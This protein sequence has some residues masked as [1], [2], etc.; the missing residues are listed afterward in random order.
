MASEEYNVGLDILGPFLLRGLGVDIELRLYRSI[1][2]KLPRFRGPGVLGNML[3]THYR[4]RQRDIVCADVL[5][6]K[7]NLDPHECVD[8]ALLFMPQLYE[9]QEV[10][11]LRA[12]LGPGQ[13]FADVGANIGFYSLLASRLVGSTGNVL[14]IEAVPT[15]FSSLQEN[16]FLNN[17]NNITAQNVGVSNRVEDLEMR[18]ISSSA[19]YKNRGSNSFLNDSGGELVTIHCEPLSALVPGPVHGMKIDIEGFEY[20]VLRRYLDEITPSDQ[21]KFLIVEQLPNMLE[22][23]GDVI[24]LLKSHGYSVDIATRRHNF[25]LSKS[26]FG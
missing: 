5:G 25:V 21:P 8:S 15:I 23:E 7:M 1:T 11:Y 26:G 24:K 16:I 19:L 2:T 10:A 17:A 20:R 14:S 18:V 9:Y 3:M 4:R 22:R 13:V 12:R 6:L